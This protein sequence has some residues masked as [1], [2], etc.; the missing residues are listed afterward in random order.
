MWHWRNGPQPIHAKGTPERPDSR[1][2]PGSITVLPEQPVAP[3]RPADHRR[4]GSQ[5]NGDVAI[6]ETGVPGPETPL[7][8]GQGRDGLR[9]RPSR[10]ICAAS[11]RI[12]PHSLRE[13]RARHPCRHIGGTERAAVR[14]PPRAV[15]LVALARA[16]PGHHASLGLERTTNGARPGVRLCQGINSHPA[17]G[18][19]RRGCGLPSTRAMVR[20]ACSSCS[21][22]WKRLPCR[23]ANIGSVAVNSSQRS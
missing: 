7:E 3:S 4:S 22:R 23:S 6:P 16:A 11:N 14:E 13:R 10:A 12:A 1:K 9:I 2:R 5:D 18:S 21:S 19:A 15:R 20:A 17:I 8:T